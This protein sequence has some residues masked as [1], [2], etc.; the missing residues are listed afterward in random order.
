[1][2]T[3][4]AQI[5]AEYILCLTMSLGSNEGQWIRKSHSCKSIHKVSYSY[6]I[7]SPSIQ[8]QSKQI[9]INY[10]NLSEMVYIAVVYSLISSLLIFI[11]NTFLLDKCHSVCVCVYVCG[12][13]YKQ[14]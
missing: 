11:L 13:S 8:L 6:T 4:P 7:P 9:G 3:E 14:I 5:F 2:A 10:F 12:Y 1:M